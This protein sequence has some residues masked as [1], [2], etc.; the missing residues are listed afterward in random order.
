MFDRKRIPLA[1]L[2]V[3]ALALSGAAAAEE[4]AVRNP[5]EMQMVP[6]PGMPTCAVGSVQSGDPSKGPSIIYSTAKPG[7]IF[8]W[9]WHTPTE[10]VMMVSGTGH[11]EMKDGKPADLKPGGFALMPSKHVHQFTCKTNCSLYIYSDGAFDMHYV[12]ASGKEL[13]PAD[14]LK[15]V[16]ETPAEAPKAGASK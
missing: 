8:P 14:A 12:D 6:F 3:L 7:C 15:A 16:N 11:V 13:S 1:V 5:R 4:P 9:H 10:H 2:S